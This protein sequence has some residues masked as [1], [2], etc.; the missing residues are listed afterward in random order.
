MTSTEFITIV[1]CIGIPGIM[2]A[3]VLVCIFWL[4][5]D[6]QPVD[7]ESDDADL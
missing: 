5:L 7:K 4:F 1:A 2:Y 3:G 6:D